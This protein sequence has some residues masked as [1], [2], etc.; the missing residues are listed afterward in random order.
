MRP[1]IDPFRRGWG[2]F[3]RRIA[4]GAGGAHQ[5]HKFWRAAPD[6]NAALYNLSHVCYQIRF[7]L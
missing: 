7:I 4:F 6:T 5:I 1:G 3:H 2:R